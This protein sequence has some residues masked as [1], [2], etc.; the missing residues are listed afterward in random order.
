MKKRFLALLLAALMC[1]SLLV[2]CSSDKDSSQTTGDNTAPV[3]T[4]ETIQQVNDYV[5][6]LA[7][8][9]NLDGATFTYVGGGGQ[10]AETE[11]EIGNIEND[12]LYKRQR[13]LEETLGITWESVVAAYE[14]GSGNTGHAVVDYVKQAVMA[15]TRVYDLVYGTLVVTCQPLFNEDHLESVSEFSVTNLSADWWPSTLEETH[16]IGGKLYFLTGPIMTSYYGDGSCLLFNKAVAEDYGIEAPYESVLDGTWTFDKM[17]EIAS[18]V[19]LNTGA[20]EYRYGSPEGLAILFANGMT[21]T[22]FTDDGVPFVESSLPAEL[23]DLAGKFSAIMGDESQT[24]I[25]TYSGSTYESISEKYGY[26]SF[27]DMFSDGGFLFYFAPTDMAS[28][29]REKDV[30]FGILPL[31]KASVDQSQYYSYANN[32]DARFCVVPRC[33]RNIANT[34]VVLEAMAALSLKHIRPA[35]YDKLLKGRSTHDTDS[36]EMLDIIFDTKIYDI[37]DIYSL[38]DQNQSGAFVKGIE[39]AIEFDDSSLASD[40]TV[41]AMMAKNQI[42][43]IMS[44]VNR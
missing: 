29:L 27:A 2:A 36:R 35:Y 10:T 9:H 23:V 43:K 11:E 25:T 31:P 17:F 14:E 7:A 8:E 5:S 40:Y 30:E 12:A 28:G 16:S 21:I 37:V 20:G 41:Y 26:E 3:E 24:A 39:K 4:D 19:P 15:D 1:T 42:K 22:K 33:T 6:S 44:M 18:A 34:D 32:W 38:G 13:E